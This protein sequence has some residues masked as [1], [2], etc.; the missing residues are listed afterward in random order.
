MR[1]TGKIILIILISMVVLSGVGIGIFLGVRLKHS[2]DLYVESLNVEL[3]SDKYTL[4]NN[5]IYITYGELVT[6]SHT[7]FTVT[8]IMSNGEMKTMESGDGTKKGNYYKFET[9]LPENPVNEKTPVGEYYIKFEYN[10][11]ISVTVSVY[12]KKSTN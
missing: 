2:D 4:D 5:E 10:E 11:D 8:A 6:L 1:K 9:D 3:I 7:D 12:V